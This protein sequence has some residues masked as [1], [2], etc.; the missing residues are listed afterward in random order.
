VRAFGRA[1]KQT[2][3]SAANVRLLDDLGLESWTAGGCL[4]LAQ[5]LRSL[6]P[7]ARI[8]S[9]TADG[10]HVGHA[11]VLLDGWVLDGDGASTVA[12]FK[13]RWA[14]EELIPGVLK[15]ERPVRWAP[16]IPQD[17]HT[18]KA[19]LENLRKALNKYL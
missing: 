14:E 15:L 10:R 7:E 8:A 3:W 18:R 13:R 17:A 16:D 5:A 9:L 2:L 1:L 19:L 11:V 12:A 4:I 6:L